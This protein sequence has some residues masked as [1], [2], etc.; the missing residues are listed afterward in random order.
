MP[1]TK[2]TTTIR[3][4][5]PIMKLFLLFA[6][7]SSVFVADAFMVIP[8]NNLSILKATVSENDE[9]LLKRLQHEYKVLQEQLLMDIEITHDEEDAELV[10]EH[11]L[12]I[13]EG[14]NTLHKHKQYEIVEQATKEM[15]RAETGMMSARALKQKALDHL[16]NAEREASMLEEIDSQHTDLEQLKSLAKEHNAD[17][18]VIHEAER[19]ELQLSFDELEAKHKIQ[20]AEFLLEQLEENEAILKAALRKLREEKNEK[21]LLAEHRSFL[22]Q[23]KD[24]IYSHPDLLARLDPHIL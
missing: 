15:D 22:D 1:Q 19:I 10:E 8:K 18:D 11:L 17:I 14:A 4:A 16:I 5:D 23:V 24:A 2:T 20:A 9:I 7:A 13:A 3:R 6:A 12:E 21:A